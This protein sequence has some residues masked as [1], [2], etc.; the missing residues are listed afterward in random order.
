MGR[1]GLALV[2]TRGELTK[3]NLNKYYLVQQK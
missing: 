3:T 1:F 2:K